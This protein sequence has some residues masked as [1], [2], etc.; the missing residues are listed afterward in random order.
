LPLLLEYCPEIILIS[1]YWAVV[2]KKELSSA[3]IV[4]KRS[5][6]NFDLDLQPVEWVNRYIVS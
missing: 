4:P 5:K 2:S 6:E 1:N 3:V